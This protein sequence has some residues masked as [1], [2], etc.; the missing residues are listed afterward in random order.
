MN[1]FKA[2]KTAAAM[3]LAAGMAFGFAACGPKT[4]EEP[5]GGKYSVTV[6]DPYGDPYAGVKVKLC[7][8]ENGTEKEEGVNGATDLEG[9]T[10]LTTKSG[11]PC[12]VYLEGLP[13]GYTY[14]PVTLQNGSS[15]TIPV[16]ADGKGQ[17]SYAIDILTNAPSNRINLN[18]F[19]PFLISNDTGNYK[20]KFT[21]ADQKI[22]YDFAPTPGDSTGFYKISSLGSVD[23]R[24]IWLHGGKTGGIYNYSSDMSP[25]D[26]YFSDNKTVTDKN[27]ELEFAVT[28]ST[29]A[30]SGGH[31]YF[32]VSLA[33]PEDVGKKFEI[34]VKYS[35][36][37][38]PEQDEPYT[39][40]FASDGVLTAAPVEGQFTDI[41]VDE[42]VPKVAVDDNG[43]YHWNTVD[44]PVLYARINSG[45]RFLSGPG[46][47][48]DPV[49]FQFICDQ[50]ND[51]RISRNGKKYNYTPMFNEYITLCN[52]DG[53]YP[54]NGDIYEFLNVY[55]DLFGHDYFKNLLTGVDFYLPDDMEWLWACGYY[56]GVT[57]PEFYPFVG[58][59]TEES[60]YVLNIDGDEAEFTVEIAANSTLYFGT[61]VPVTF[62][63]AADNVTATYGQTAYGGADGFTVEVVI[64]E[65]SSGLQTVAITNAGAAAVKVTIKITV[66]EQPE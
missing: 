19:D 29:I 60:P 21:S 55:I 34:T 20:V 30:Q 47:S 51:F 4:P 52:K 23:A 22:Y 9:K 25:D 66:N 27:F 5:A 59:G 6:L 49:T 7:E 33:N 1:N 12:K 63:S 31:C 43:W 42:L 3:L 48:S 64:P 13:G 36:E 41:P 24:V 35:R 15:V 39:D 61:R 58:L 56:E 65:N 46:D 2:F 45:L 40:V 14:A 37:Y 28:P 57:T 10:E 32:E 44:G 18:A 54:V 53:L 8:I 26:E 17:G 11:L 38:I 16:G 62:S 50:G